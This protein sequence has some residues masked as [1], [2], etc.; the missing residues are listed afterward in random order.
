M[1]T[2][3]A[4][5]RIGLERNPIPLQ[6]KDTGPGYS[7]ILGNSWLIPT[8]ST[9]RTHVNW[10]YSTSG[11]W[12]PNSLTDTVYPVPVKNRID[13]H[14]TD[15]DNHSDPDTSPHPERTYDQHA[16]FNVTFHN[17][18]EDQVIYKSGLKPTS[19]N[20]W[21]RG[22]DAN[23]A[24]V[25]LTGPKLGWIPVLDLKSASNWFVDV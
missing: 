2:I 11:S 17:E 9:P 13:L 6:V 8:Y 22:D 21:I 7:V 20:P 3:S 25:T 12:L 23:G 15:T 19:D 16:G 10:P 18:F 1:L 4:G 14:L 24:A 5:D